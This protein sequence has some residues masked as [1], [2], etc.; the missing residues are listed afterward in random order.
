MTRDESAELRRRL[1]RLGG[2]KGRSSKRKTPQILRGQNLPEGEV[3]ETAHGPTYRLEERYPT[4]HQHG[5]YLLSQTLSFPA[6]LAADVVR[7]PA[8][9]KTSLDQLMFLDTETT[10]LVGGAG[11]LVFLVGVGFFKGDEFYLRQYFLRDPAEEMGMLSLLQEDLDWAAGYVTYN[12]QAFDLPLLENRYVLSLKR[13]MSLVSAPNLDLLHVSR[14]LWQRSLPDCKLSTVEQY[15]LGVERSEEDVPGAWIPGMYLDYLR[16]GDAS[17]MSRVIYHN[18]IDVLSLVSLTGQVL[19]RF[20][21]GDP[22]S[23]SD[24]E[25]LAVARWHQ[26]SGRVSPAE[27]AFKRAIVSKQ[28][29]LKIEALR[30]YSVH[31]KR[32]GRRTEAVNLWSMWH[33]LAPED[34]R[35]CIELAKYYEWECKDYEA[36]AEWTQAAFQCLTHWPK[37]WRR[38]RIWAELENRLKRLTRKGKSQDPQKK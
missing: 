7:N 21:K 27:S 8:L 32:E 15:V 33:D 9:N 24:G 16:T 14:R 6:K 30:R 25:A 5:D 19:T 37:D 34:E 18:L 2:G 28:P 35:P 26:D 23:L 29:E 10:G 13:K 1:R 38:E 12:G 4:D 36:A 20:E 31:L 22:V 3:I 11:T 17:E